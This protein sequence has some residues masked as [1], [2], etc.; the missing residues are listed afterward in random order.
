MINKESTPAPTPGVFDKV[1]NTLQTGL[2]TKKA[3][4][5]SQAASD[6]LQHSINFSKNLPYIII[7]CCGGGFF[8][9]LA[10]AFIPLV[11]LVPHKFSL[12]FAMGGGCFLAAIGLVRGPEKFFYSLLEGEK[13]KWTIA[14]GASIFGTLACALVFKSR[15]LA[16]ICAIA[17]VILFSIL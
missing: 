13:L 8:M 3:K 9:I 14:Y 17:Q 11:L 2:L 7:L 12:L 1:K 10:M 4:E 16:L 6:K 15:P 5:M